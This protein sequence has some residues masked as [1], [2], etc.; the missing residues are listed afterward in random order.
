[1]TGRVRVIDGRSNDGSFPQGAIRAVCEMFF[2]SYWTIGK[3]WWRGH[4]S[5]TTISRMVANV[6]SYKT[7]NVGRKKKEIDLDAIKLVLL[8]QLRTICSLASKIGLS[9]SM[10]GQ[11]VKEGKIRSHTSSIRSYLT[12]GNK[13]A[14]ATSWRN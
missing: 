9:K 1:M 2:A 7:G 6:S 3:I 8:C 11:R 10:V 14:C 5:F 4:S 13:L 12:L